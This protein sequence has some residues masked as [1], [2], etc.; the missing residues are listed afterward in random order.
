MR[1][2]GCC[3]PVATRRRSDTGT[4][5]RQGRGRGLL[6]HARL[7][8][9]QCPRLWHRFQAPPPPPRPTAASLSLCVGSWGESSGA[10]GSWQG[11][12]NDD[13]SGRLL[14]AP[15]LRACPRPRAARTL[16]PTRLLPGR[17]SG[18][19]LYQPGGVGPG[20]ERVMTGGRD[21][22]VDSLTRPATPCLSFPREPD[23]GP[24]L[25]GRKGTA[26]QHRAAPCRPQEGGGVRRKVRGAGIPGP[27]SSPARV[28]SCKSLRRRRLV[29][30]RRLEGDLNGSKA[31]E[32][33]GRG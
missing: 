24:R 30:R 32:N 5:A 26:A 19:L 9:G 10:V 12:E 23:V 31:G 6:G 16:P 4:C 1:A 21:A 33:L 22:W 28:T 7:R 11:S 15:G 2:G 17:R 27:G 14:L 29:S 8:G 18:W 25:S 13:R 20:E 3:H